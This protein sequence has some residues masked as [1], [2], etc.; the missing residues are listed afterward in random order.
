MPVQHL[1]FPI[2]DKKQLLQLHAGD[3]VSLSGVV[4]AARDTAHKRLMALLEKGEA[5]P[6]CLEGALLYY[7]GPSPAPEGMVIG[8]AGP[9]T[10][11]RMDPYTPR[12]YRLGLA[13]TL[14]KGKR[15]PEVRKVL[16]ECEAVYL[17]ATGGAAAL[18]SRHIVKNKIIAFSELGPEAIRELVLENFPAVVIYDAYGHSVFQ[19]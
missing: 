18:L 6:F 16:Q 12:L 17:G 8:S 19:E 4:Y 11:S 15:S 9:T 1:E 2:A 10:S 13:A 14:G 3:V 7:V 5:L